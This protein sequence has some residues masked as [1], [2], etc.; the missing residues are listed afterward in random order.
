MIDGVVVVNLLRWLSG[1]HRGAIPVQLT[2]ENQAK[3]PSCR[4]NG[5]TCMEAMQLAD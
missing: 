3:S 2:F 4:C 5:S 1:Y